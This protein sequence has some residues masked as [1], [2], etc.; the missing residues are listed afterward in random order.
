MPVVAGAAGPGPHNPGPCKVIIQVSPEAGL[1][2]SSQNQPVILTQAPLNWGTAEAPTAVAGH[3]APL[4]LVSSGP[5]TIMPT[6]AT[7]V[8]QAGTEDHRPQAPLPVAQ[9]A[10]I[11]LPSSSGTLT[12][13]VCGDSGPAATRSQSPPKSS[14]NPNSVYEN[15]RRW[16]RFKALARR[17]L[18]QT[19]DTEALSCFFIPVLRTLARLK[20]TMS[21]EEGL[22]RALQE[23]QGK[24]NYDRMIYYDMAAKFMEFEAEEE[25]EVQKLQWTNG[26]Q[27]LP[28]P[29]P[30]RPGPK[31]RPQARAARPK[32][33]KPQQP[34]KTKA[35]EE[36]P[37]EAVQEYMDIMD[38]LL[39]APDSVCRAPLGQRTVDREEQ[40]EEAGTCP[41]P[42]LL[43]YVYELCSQEAFVTKAEAILHP[44]FLEYL[45]SPESQLDFPALAEELEEEE[46]LTPAQLVEKRLQTP[47]D[48]EVMKARPQHQVSL[49]DSSP[50]ESAAGYCTPTPTWGH[51]LG[52]GI[53]TDGQNHR[54]G[55]KCEAPVRML[56]TGAKSRDRM[57]FGH[58]RSC[59]RALSTKSNRSQCCRGL[60]VNIDELETG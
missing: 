48:K 8:T 39:K 18:P 10:P 21:L 54:D 52:F 15:F 44:S 59:H 13:W 23:W 14:R 22:H 5:E 43:S 9:V 60:R 2:E 20:P 30:P 25:M 29:A 49:K 32:T 31:A 56:R 41:D 17:Y 53:T 37:P 58:C 3:P 42:G 6:P 28:L 47:Q 38:E 19:P 57:F 24:S 46:G 11:T 36:I 26:V 35:P 55:G 51:R 1:V 40:Q 4:Y 27:G 7:T 34:P 45:D 16:Q 12:Q 33:H 50:A